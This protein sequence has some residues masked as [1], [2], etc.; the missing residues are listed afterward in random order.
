MKSMRWFWVAAGLGAAAWAVG[1]GDDTTQ[2]PPA[3]FVIDVR[4]GTWNITETSSSRGADS[5]LARG[6]VV[7]DTADVLCAKTL[8]LASPG[9]LFPISGEIDSVGD[10]FQFQYRFQLADYGICYFYLHEVGS[11]T[12]TDTTFDV[13]ADFVQEIKA[14]D[15]KDALA[16]E[17]LYGR[18]A[19]DCTLHVSSVGA[20]ASSFGDTICVADPSPA[21]PLPPYSPLLPHAARAALRGH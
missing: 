12:I 15:P 6:V 16:A 3:V 7:V 19:D 9:G 5:C 1:C 20:W 13:V 14:K 21:A 18:F 4:N 17:L 11:G 2:P 10:E 8:L